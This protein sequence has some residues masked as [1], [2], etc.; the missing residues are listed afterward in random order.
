MNEREFIYWEEAGGGLGVTRAIL[1]GTTGSTVVL[2]YNDITFPRGQIV[3]SK[4]QVY[5]EDAWASLF[6][7]G[8]WL[9]L[10][11]NSWDYSNY[12]RQL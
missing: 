11:C 12:Y 7:A 10:V 5:Q 2:S 8:K 9:R 3:I 6:K 1:N 4:L